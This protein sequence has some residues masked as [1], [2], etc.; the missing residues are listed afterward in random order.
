MQQIVAQLP[1]AFTD[2]KGVTKSYI[3][4]ANAPERVVVPTNDEKLVE[5]EIK[6]AKSMDNQLELNIRI[7]GKEKQCHL[8]NLLKR[9]LL[10]RNISVKEL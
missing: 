10:K 3:L 8:E 7:H 6:H 5:L 9:N 1:D 4:V 2:V